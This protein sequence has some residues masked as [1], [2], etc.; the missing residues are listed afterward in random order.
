M[1]SHESVHMNIA[2]AKAIGY[3]NYKNCWP[4]IQHYLLR[5]LNVD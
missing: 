3:Q 1:R 5:R 2:D 4:K